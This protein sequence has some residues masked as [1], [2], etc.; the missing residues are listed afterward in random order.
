MFLGDDRMGRGWRKRGASSHVVQVDDSNVELAHVRSGTSMD[1]MRWIR[2]C[3]GVGEC[4][5]TKGTMLT[6]LQTGP[7]NS[8]FCH[9]DAWQRANGSLRIS[10]IE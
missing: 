3:E 10:D 8:Q 2:T 9:E 6:L 1:G 7:V 4:L 5:L